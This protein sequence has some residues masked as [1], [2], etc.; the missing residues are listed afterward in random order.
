V[1]NL[2]RYS[3]FVI[4]LKRSIGFCAEEGPSRRCKCKYQRTSSEKGYLPILQKF[5]RRRNRRSGFTEENSE[6]PSAARYQESCTRFKHKGAEKEPGGV[7]EVW[8]IRE[9][10][11]PEPIVLCMLKMRFAISI[12]DQS[13]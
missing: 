6:V 2:R 9:S 4:P 13:H 10:R 5:S 12:E 1:E 7:I 11:F 8:L 3:T